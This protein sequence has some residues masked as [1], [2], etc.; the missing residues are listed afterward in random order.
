MCLIACRNLFSC[1]FASRSGAKECCGV[2][3]ALIAAA[4]DRAVQVQSKR[5]RAQG[6]GVEAA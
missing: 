4:T 3:V 5:V 2:V 1:R 6:R